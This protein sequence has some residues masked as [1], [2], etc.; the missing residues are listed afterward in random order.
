[1][2]WILQ[3]IFDAFGEKR[4]SRI[5]ASAVIGGL[6]T[7]FVGLRYRLA[8]TLPQYLLWTAGGAA[9]GLL[10]GFLLALGDWTIGGD[11]DESH[12][13]TGYRSVIVILALVG[14]TVLVCLVC[15]LVTIIH[16]S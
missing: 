1:M 9:M 8:D 3:W 2:T 6:V 13:A 4:R 16:L 15:F 14:L 10:G 7:L 5:V 11:D 12:T